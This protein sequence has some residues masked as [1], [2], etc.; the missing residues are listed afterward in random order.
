VFLRD[1]SDETEIGVAQNTYLINTRE[2]INH[3][4]A[5]LKRD[6]FHFSFSEQADCSLL[7]KRKNFIRTKSNNKHCSV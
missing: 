1:V 5:L 4:Q 3:E 6:Y 7:F 2:E